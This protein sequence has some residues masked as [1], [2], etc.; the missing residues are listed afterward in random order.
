MRDRTGRPNCVIGPVGTILTSTD[1]PPP[2]TR[3]W[4]KRRKAEICCAVRGGLLSLDD[5]CA[6]YQ[7]SVEEFLSWQRA[8]KRSS[9]PASTESADQLTRTSERSAIDE[10]VELLLHQAKRLP[11]EKPAL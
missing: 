2:K 8:I 6:R 3:R 9:L 7:L 4:V 10:K 5:A 1:L 11:N